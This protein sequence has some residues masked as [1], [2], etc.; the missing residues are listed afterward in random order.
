M[1]KLRGF[2]VD[3]KKEILDLIDIR[4]S[5]LYHPDLWSEAYDEALRILREDCIIEP[6]SLSKPDM[7]NSSWIFIRRSL[8]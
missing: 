6:L 1:I 3:L 8:G 4:G 5:F 7:I 2:I